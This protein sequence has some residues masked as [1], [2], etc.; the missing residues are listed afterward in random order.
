MMIRSFVFE[1]CGVFASWLRTRLS[2]R[3][4][5]PFSFSESFAGGPAWNLLHCFWNGVPTLFG[6]CLITP[7]NCGLAHLASQDASSLLS[8]CCSARTQK[9][10]TGG[11]AG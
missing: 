11:L 8:P 5:R 1:G 7:A 9:I 10:D 3:L 6:I 4:I 2:V